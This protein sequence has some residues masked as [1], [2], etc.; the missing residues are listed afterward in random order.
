MI[1]REGYR[2]NVGIV[3]T[4]DKQQV[5]LAK[6]FK[7]EGWQLPQGGIDKG[8]N[9]LEALLREL[10]EEVGLRAEHIEVVAK[11]PKWLRYDLPKNKRSKYCVGQKQVW[12]LLKL[13]GSESDIKLDTHTKIEFEDWKWVDYWHPIEAIIDFKKPIYEDMLKALAPVLFNNQHKVP[14]QYS[15]PLKCSAITF[16]K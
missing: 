7:K 2:A 6:R 8:E 9:E 1:D 5:L 3:I 10:E 12:F 15:R 14:V 13:I 16:S 11:T 4:N